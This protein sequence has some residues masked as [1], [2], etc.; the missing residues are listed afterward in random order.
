MSTYDADVVI[1]GSGFGGS[2]S[3]NRLALAGLKV[4]VLERG[5]WRDS[6]PVRSMGIER[7][8]PFPY[9]WKAITHFLRSV[10][11]GSWDLTL[12]KSG[13]YEVFRYPGLDVF[14]VSAVGGGSHGWFGF[15]TEPQDSAYWKER[16]PGL[17]PAEVEKYYDKIRAD[18][19]AVQFSQD[20]WLP[21]SIWTHLPVSP[22]RRCLPA[23]PQP[24]LAIKLPHSKSEVGQ[25]TEGSGGVKRQTCAFDGDGLLG[26]RGGAKASVEFI[27]LAPVLNKG[28]T[29]LDMCEVTKISRD[30]AAGAGE[31]A[32]HFSTLRNGQKEIVHSKRVILA[33]GTMNT[34]RLLF[35]SSL[36]RGSLAPMPSLGNTFGG[37][38]DFIGA[39]LRESAQPST[40]EAPTALGR[41]TVDGQDVPFVAMWGLS[42]FDTLPLL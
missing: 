7:R 32:V 30:A 36:G 27:Y 39:W 38:G 42:G 25:I 19:G 3:A 20:F 4:M 6:L 31:Y 15:T 33:A 40:F 9:G 28:V 29:V 35:A 22:G 8:A 11:H 34:L 23:N 2:I 1:I 5:P 41:F 10:H 17:N 14:A 13:M 24:Y 37:N 26:S 21:H 18:L 12:N 16:H